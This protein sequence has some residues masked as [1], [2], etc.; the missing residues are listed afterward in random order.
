MNDWYANGGTMD[1]THWHGP[2]ILDHNAH[3]HKH[4]DGDQGEHHQRD[5]DNQVGHTPNNPRSCI[6]C[7]RQNGHSLQCDRPANKAIDLSF[8]GPILHD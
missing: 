4:M 2:A 5:E 6:Y 3:L 8:L 7:G 1:D